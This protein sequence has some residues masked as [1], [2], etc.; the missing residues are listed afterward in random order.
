MSKFIVIGER[1]HCISPSIRKALAERNPEPILARAG[2]QIAAGADYLD[3]NIG[4]GG[5]DAE[6]LMQW[7]VKTIQSNCGNIPLA[8]DTANKKAIA[9][10]LRVYDRTNGKPIINSADAGD[11]MDNIDLAADNDAIVIALCAAGTVAADNDERM[12]FCQTMLEHA[13]EL[14][15]SEQDIWFDPSFVVVKGMQEKYAEILEA[16]RLFKEM[17]LNSTGGISNNSN[18]A[19]KNVRTVMDSTVL[20]MAIANG[21]TSAICNPCDRRVMETI[22][23]ADLFLGNT[24]YADSYLDI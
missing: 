21:L 18:G 10:G 17:G 24:L 14:G 4:P 19:P 23:T 13:M 1:I 7:A 22:R 6:E 8:L 2:E 20:A 12:A 15:M 11:R 16:C 9:A 3:V 5:E